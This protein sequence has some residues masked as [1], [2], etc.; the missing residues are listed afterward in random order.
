MEK[1]TLCLQPVI[2]YTQEMIA[3]AAVGR[4]N[5]TVCMTLLTLLK[6]VEQIVHHLARHMNHPRLS[7]HV[8]RSNVEEGAEEQPY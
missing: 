4:R 7:A 8:V 1:G 5:T 3:H 2:K 6:N